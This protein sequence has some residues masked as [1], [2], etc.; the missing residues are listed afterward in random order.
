MKT[1]DSQPSVA[2]QKLNVV[3]SWLKM[4][5]HIEVSQAQYVKSSIFFPS[6]QKNGQ[7]F[8]HI[9]LF[10]SPIK[11]L[12]TA[13][14]CLVYIQHSIILCFNNVG[15]KINPTKLLFVLPLML[16]IYMNISLLMKNKCW[17]MLRLDCFAWSPRFFGMVFI[18][19]NVLKLKSCQNK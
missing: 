19:L 18:Q 14:T 2:I 4:A 5:V 17:H 7:V 16:T 9:S 6:D 1:P 8:E 13:L 10:S 15:I 11:T 12:L 3:I